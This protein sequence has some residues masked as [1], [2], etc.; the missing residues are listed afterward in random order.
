[1]NPKILP[2]IRL[3]TTRTKIHP[4]IF[5][6]TQRSQPKTLPQISRLVTVKMMLHLR[7]AKDKKDLKPFK[8]EQY[9]SH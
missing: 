9:V 5:H 3:R 7:R 2:Q 8:L 6:P 1:M 4:K